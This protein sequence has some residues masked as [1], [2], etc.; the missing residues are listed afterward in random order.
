MTYDPTPLREA[1][2]RLGLSQK[3]IAARSNV[4]LGTVSKI[5][6][7]KADGTLIRHI[8]AV[9][10]ALGLKLRLTLNVPPPEPPPAI[11]DCRE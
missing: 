1:A 5:M 11:A 8:S 7:G 3:Q 2:K 10:K 4:G 6:Q 9:A